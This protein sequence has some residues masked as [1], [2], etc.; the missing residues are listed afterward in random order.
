M[1]KGPKRGKR[2]VLRLYRSYNYVDKDPA[3]DKLRTVLQD[4]KVSHKNLSVLSGVSPTT[5][6]NWFDGKTKRPQHT[7][8]AAAA[9]ALG[10]DWELTHTQTMDY[11]SEMLKAK[12]WAEKNEK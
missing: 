3:I 4:E 10:Y 6:S 8:L 9:A 12:R 1:T 2:G 11:K 5:I 7:T